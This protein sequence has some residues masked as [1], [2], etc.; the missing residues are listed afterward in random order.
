RDAAQRGMARQVGNSG[1]VRPGQRVLFKQFDGLCPRHS[2]ESFRQY[3]AELYA[4][5][6]ASRIVAETRILDEARPREHA[7]AKA[8]PFAGVLDDNDNLAIA[9]WKAAVGIDGGVGKSGA[10]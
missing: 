2:R 7:C 5:I 1:Y 8:A 6:H 10:G 3:G 4:T 9:A